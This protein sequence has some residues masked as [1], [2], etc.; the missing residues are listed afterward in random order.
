MQTDEDLKRHE[1]LIKA[2]FYRWTMDTYGGLWE[3]AAAALEARTGVAIPAESLRQNIAPVSRKAGQPPRRFKD[4]AR[5]RAL[6]DFL[7]SVNYLYAQE[8]TDPGP[9]GL[10]AQVLAEFVNA[11]T[12]TP[13]SAPLR[14]LQG[15]FTGERSASAGYTEALELQVH[16]AG[17]DQ[18]VRLTALSTLRDD[19]QDAPADRVE[20]QGWAVCNDQGFYAFL[21]RDAYTARCL[22]LLQAAPALSGA[23]V[24]N[25]LALL[26]YESAFA[27]TLSKTVTALGDD[28]ERV[29]YRLPARTEQLFLFL[30]RS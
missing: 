24:L 23:A 19:A 4:P 26:C 29:D 3:Q 2:R 25:D 5:L 18:P 30:T 14:R 15:R 20:S 27:G 22:L 13:D 21:L 28:L 9:S 17:P 1:R 6:K 16:Y 12:G 7:L 11:G 8:L 10:V